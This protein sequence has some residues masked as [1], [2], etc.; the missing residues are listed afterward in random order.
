MLIHH[1]QSCWC[2]IHHWQS[3]W[4]WYITDKAASVRYITD[5][6]VDVWYITNISIDIV[7]PPPPPTFS[8]L[9]SIL[10]ISPTYHLPPCTV[11]YRQQSFFPL[12]IT[13]WN[14]LPLEL[15]R[16]LRGGLQRPHL[17]SPL[18]F[19][20]PI[21]TQPWKKPTFRKVDGPDRVAPELLL[22]TDTWLSCWLAVVWVERPVLCQ[23]T[24][25]LSTCGT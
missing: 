23:H 11:S 5:K 7:V 9:Q 1:W 21:P 25:Q 3:C 10:H 20:H 22:V 19:P 13:E 8:T 15:S 6:V 16:H 2:L 17:A 12:T 4:C 18:L 24:Q 14:S